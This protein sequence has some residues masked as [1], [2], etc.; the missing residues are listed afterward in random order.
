MIIHTAG[1]FGQVHLSATRVD[2]NGATLWNPAQQPVSTA[3]SNKDDVQLTEEEDG[4]IV[5]VW[6][7]DRNPVGIYAQAIDSFRTSPPPWLSCRPVASWCGWSKTL[8]TCRSCCFPPRSRAWRGSKCSMPRARWPIQRAH[9]GPGPCTTAAGRTGPRNVHHPGHRRWAHRGRALGE[10]GR[11]LKRG[12]Y[13]PARARPYLCRTQAVT[14]RSPYS[15]EILHRHGQP[16]PDQE[17]QDLGILDGV[18]TNPSLMA[19]KASPGR[20]A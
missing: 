13:G 19:R 2:L 10:V 17:A 16:G 3:S 9:P 14:S 15:H 4:L 6:Q 11:G 8:P 7:D 12:L 20:T 1:T 18:T 5:A